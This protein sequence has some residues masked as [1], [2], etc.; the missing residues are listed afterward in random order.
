MTPHIGASTKEA[1]F[2][3]ADSVASETLKALR[4]EIVSTPVNLPD[5]AGLS[6][7]LASHYAYLAGK[8]GA[9]S[10]QFMRQ[11]FV[12]GQ[13][14]F[15][16][17]G[18]LNPEDFALIKLSYLK[19]FLQ[20]TLDETVSYVNVL[21]IAHSKGIHMIEQEDHGFSDYESA[22]RVQ[23]KGGGHQITIGGTVMGRSRVRLSYLNGFA[24]EIEPTGCIL[25]IENED[26][27]GV[28]GHV[29]TILAKHSININRFELSR[30]NKGGQAMAMVM[31][32]G[33]VTGQALSDL[34]QYPHINRVQTIRLGG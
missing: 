17:R 29:G 11:E 3:I 19:S 21:Q 14:E 34:T 5:I 7:E 12:P 8:L 18:K 32:D 27:P 25:S 20:G 9:F 26:K 16:F 31:V 13:I 4:G 30:E 22:I 23:V 1:Q 15:L 10:R 24:F 28:I 6:G 33:D 2:R